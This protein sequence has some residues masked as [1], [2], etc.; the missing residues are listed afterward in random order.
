MIFVASNVLVR[1]IMTRNVKVVRQDTTLHEVVATLSRFDI[2][3]II[4][5]QAEKPVGII[6]AKDALVRAVEHGMPLSAITAGMVASSPVITIGEQA[7][8][9]EVVEL[10]KRSKIKRLPVV[11]DGKI[12]GI[13]SDTD[14]LFAVPSMLGVMEEVCRQK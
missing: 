12:V 6:T 5:V 8:V 1:D 7:S 4:V 11:E 9:D 10:M 2:N 3:S 13:V 14:I